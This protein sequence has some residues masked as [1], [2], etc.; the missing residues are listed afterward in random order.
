MWEACRVPFMPELCAGPTLARFYDKKRR[1]EPEAVP[2]FDGLIAGGLDALVGSLAAE[3]ELHDPVR[4]GVKGTRAFEA[5]VTEMNA[6]I[7]RRNI[8]GRECRTCHV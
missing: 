8:T 6:W 7:A 3:P 4:A 5:L 2:Y 1:D